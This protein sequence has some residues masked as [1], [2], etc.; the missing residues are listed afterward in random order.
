M[1][2]NLSFDRVSKFAQDVL[3][4]SGINTPVSKDK[5]SDEEEEEEEEDSRGF[6]FLSAFGGGQ[7]DLGD[8]LDLD[9]TYEDS[10]SMTLEKRL[11][12]L[13]VEDSYEPPSKVR[14]FC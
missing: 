5:M 11:R 13:E 10:E 12:E 9:E 8:D 1:W 14:P 4:D 2:A 6:G 7:V 3:T